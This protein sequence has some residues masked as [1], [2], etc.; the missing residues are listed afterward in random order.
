MARPYES[1]PL[2][3][4][5]IAT[6]RMTSASRNVNRSSSRKKAPSPVSSAGITWSTSPVMVSAAKAA[7]MAASTCAPMYG[8]TCE[9]GIPPRSQK[10]SVTAGL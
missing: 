3:V 9:P 10:A 7:T 2:V 5:A 1:L 6:L 8:I 4:G